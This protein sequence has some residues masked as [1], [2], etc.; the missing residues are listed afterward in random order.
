MRELE[1]VNRKLAGFV[2]PKIIN[3]KGSFKKGFPQSRPVKTFPITHR[4]RSKNFEERRRRKN[5]EHKDLEGPLG[6]M[7]KLLIVTLSWRRKIIHNMV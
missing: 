2:L 6:R 1:K 7:L 5:L 3:Q 4:Q